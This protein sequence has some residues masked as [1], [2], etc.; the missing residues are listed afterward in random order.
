MHCCISNA[1]LRKFADVQNAKSFI[2][3]RK[4]DQ[5]IKLSYD[6]TR[7]SVSQDMAR[8]ALDHLATWSGGNRNG[9]REC[10]FPGFSLCHCTNISKRVTKLIFSDHTFA[11]TELIVSRLDRIKVERL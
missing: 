11:Q 2:S 3:I 6:D 10:Q 7:T 1:G 5:A 8:H 9:N 4:I